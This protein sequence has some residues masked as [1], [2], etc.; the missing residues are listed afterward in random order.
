MLSISCFA[1]QTKAQAFGGTVTNPT[2]ALLNTTPDTALYS[3]QSNNNSYIGIQAVITTATGTQAGTSILQG[4]EYLTGPYFVLTPWLTTGSDTLTLSNTATQSVLWS[5]AKP[6]I[7]YYR[8]ITKG[9]TTV[10]GQVIAQIYG[11]KVP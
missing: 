4:S 9:A 6:P 11:L 2:N 8:I 1:S 5:L 10:T 3:L 7:N